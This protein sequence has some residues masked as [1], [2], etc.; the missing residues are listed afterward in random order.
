MFLNSREPAAAALVMRLLG[1]KVPCQGEA[2]Q[3]LR[4]A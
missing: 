2:H 1:G 4:A 3:Q